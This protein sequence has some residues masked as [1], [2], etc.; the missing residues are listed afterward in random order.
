MTRHVRLL[1]V[2]A[3]TALG[4]GP[5]GSQPAPPAAG[6]RQAKGGPAFDSPCDPSPCPGVGQPASRAGD[7]VLVAERRPADSPP[8]SSLLVAPRPA[9]LFSLIS[10]TEVRPSSV[11]DC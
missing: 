8:L 6:F 7:R 2:T 9:A 5:A 4:T 11:H 1:V 3:L 10:S